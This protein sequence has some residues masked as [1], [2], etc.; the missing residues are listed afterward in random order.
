MRN[1]AITG[2]GL[3]CALGAMACEGTVT[4]DRP[5]PPVLQVLSPERGTMRA[6]LTQIEVRG[7]VT[8]SP[9]S[10]API[11]KVEVNG[12]AAAVGAA[13][14]W[15]VTVPLGSGTNLIHT[16]ALDAEGGTA[17][18]T[19][20]VLTG[21][22]RPLDMVVQ[23]AAQLG[24]SAVAFDKLGDTAATLVAQSDLGSF[25]APYNPVIAK[26]LSNGEEDCLYGKVS[27]LPGLDIANAFLSLQ[28]D[29]AGLVLDAELVGVI[30]PLHTRY[31]AACLDG[32]TDITVRAQ[33]ARIRG[34]LQ[35]TVV[36]GRFDVKL[37]NPTVTWTGFTVDASGV[38]GAV[39]DLLN[40][41][42]E[43]A[44]TLSWAVER[45]MAPMVDKAL[46]GVSVPDPSFELMGHTL[47]IAMTPADVAFD[48]AGA[49][50][51]LD[52]ALTV[53]DAATTF[54]Y[55]ENQF[56]PGRGDAGFALALA[57]DSFNQ[58]LAGMWSA[59]VMSMTVEKELAMFDGVVL[60]AKLPPVISAAEDGS[61]RLVMA[62]LM[63]DFLSH[64]EV[65]AR[66]AMNVEMRLKIEPATNPYAARVTLDLPVL[67]ADMTE[68]VLGIPDTEL[69]KMFPGAV[70]ST[71]ST[72]APIL[73]A[74][75]LPSIYGITVGDLRFG[76]NTGYVTLS[77]DVY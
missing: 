67:R 46:A 47:V 73:N 49:E 3:A 77:G 17:D 68:N 65:M 38:P 54:V 66:A 11:T 53:T 26:G 41:D 59:G 72:F 8:P 29:D 5:E 31:A 19:R 64:G 60:D 22:L 52:A 43:I 55:T 62:D 37:V 74:V 44:K 51:V 71:I 25:V 76:G 36:G 48:P 9:D 42:D 32:D 69:E 10:L 70:E 57:D 56:P 27:V 23:N 21:D 13:G 30:I 15:R 28:P 4:G 75:P 33:R 16:V 40:L 63:V 12:V 34:N 24:L 14:D 6:D 39:L 2:L 61:L 58:A 45:F 50:V 18:D 1:L 20:G 35:I 7:T